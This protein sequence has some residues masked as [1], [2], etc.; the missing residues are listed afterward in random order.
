[1]FENMVKNDKF[2]LRRYSN[3]AYV[4]SSQKENFYNFFGFLHQK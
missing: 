3:M 4:E 1:M 2:F